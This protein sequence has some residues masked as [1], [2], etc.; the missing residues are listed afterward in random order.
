MEVVPGK[1]SGLQGSAPPVLLLQLKSCSGKYSIIVTLPETKVI[2]SA[3]RKMQNL[4][5][6]A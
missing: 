5:Q 6:P 3:N 1:A 2:I 4:V